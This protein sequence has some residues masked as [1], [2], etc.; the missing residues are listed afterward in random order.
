LALTV[1]LFFGLWGLSTLVMGATVSILPNNAMIEGLARGLNDVV[2]TPFGAFAIG[3]YPAICEELLYRGAILGLLLKG[4]NT[5]RAVV[6]QALAFSLAHIISIRLPWTF[7][8]GLVMGWI[9]VRTGSLWACMAVHFVFNT[10]IAVL[11]P[12]FMG[13]QSTEFDSTQLLYALPLLL[14]LAVLP[15]FSKKEVGE[16]VQP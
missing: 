9:R 5:R 3:V 11:L 12:Y 14:G 6:I 15:L 1:P 13:E 7:V 10:T 16:V 8:F 2:Q 4:G